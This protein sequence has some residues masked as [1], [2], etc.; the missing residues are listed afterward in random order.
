MLIVDDN[1]KDATPRVCAELAAKYPLLHDPNP[2]K[3]LGDMT[4]AERDAVVKRATEQFQQELDRNAPAIGR[5]LNEE[6]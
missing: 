4:Y 6:T 5:I 2:N 3:R 1:S